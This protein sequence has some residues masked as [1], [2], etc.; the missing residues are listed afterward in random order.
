M[1]TLF[2]LMFFC[3]FGWAA[4][5]HNHGQW[6]EVLKKYQI[7]DGR[8]R[9]ADLKAEFAEPHHPLRSYLTSLEK[10]TKKEYDLW[11]REQQMA[12]LINAYNAF[13]IKL[14]IDNYP[15]EG[16]K[17]I[18]GLLR[19]P[20][21]VTFFHLLDG[22]L[23]NLDPIEHEY[24]RPKFKDFRIHAAV[25]CASLSCPKLWPE[26]FTPT[27]LNAQLE[28]AFKQ[29]L[30]DPA[31]NAYSPTH[32]K[33]YLSEIFK[34]FKEDFE[35]KADYPKVIEQMGP[36]QAKEAIKAGG[37][38][39]WI[40]YNWTLN[41]VSNN[42]SLEREIAAKLQTPSTIDTNPKGDQ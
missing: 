34:W 38:V 10:V 22:T 19:S 14:I 32:G 18:G 9:Y 8:V 16:I 40:A 21:G 12:F 31:R 33:L 29:F 11:S 1:K 39:E 30:H 26:A 17:K 13:T 27:K 20:W 2:F 4:F 24:L 5:D 37:K 36:S 25:N 35:F 23:K 41:D 3:G 15:V 42:T 28:A 6:T 7:S